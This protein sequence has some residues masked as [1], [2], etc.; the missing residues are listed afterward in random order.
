M[1]ERH[2]PRDPLSSHHPD[3]PED[4]LASAL[5]NAAAAGQTAAAPAPV[6]TIMARGDRVRRRRTVAYAVAACLAVGGTGLVAAAVLPLGGGAVV[7]ATTPSGSDPDRET[8]SPRRSGAEPTASGSRFS[9]TPTGTGT[10][11]TGHGSATNAPTSGTETTGPGGPAARTTT[12]VPPPGSTLGG[13]AHST[14]LRTTAP[15]D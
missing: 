4:A 11:G 5:K 12:S 6:A 10:T 2:D 8:P 3:A 14:T 1:P 9:G 7:P 15:T 13:A